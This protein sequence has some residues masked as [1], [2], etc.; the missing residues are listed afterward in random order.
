MSDT[1]A[2]PTG[3][4]PSQGATAVTSEPQTLGAGGVGDVG[5]GGVEPGR[6]IVLQPLPPGLWSIILGAVVAALGPLGGFLMGSIIGVGDPDAQV[7][8][9]FLALL[10][11]ILIGGVGAAV[12]ILGGLRLARAHA[13]D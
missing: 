7:N 3:P 4:D 9:M 2:P 12:A 10:I 6:D 13:R 1:A 11:G 5:P 8:P